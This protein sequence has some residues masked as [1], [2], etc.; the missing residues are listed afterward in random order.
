MVSPLKL[1]K[2]QHLYREH[3]QYLRGSCDHGGSFWEFRQGN[4]VLLE[5]HWCLKR[6]GQPR[7]TG[8]GCQYERL[9]PG[10]DTFCLELWGC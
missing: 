3:L 6:T 10:S 4:G 8:Q 5:L 1:S 9:P 2:C 7:K